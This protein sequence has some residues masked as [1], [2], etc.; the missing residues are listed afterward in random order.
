[1]VH[2]SHHHCTTIDQMH[3]GS[4]FPAV[5]QNIVGGRLTTAMPFER[6][7]GNQAASIS[8]YSLLLYIKIEGHKFGKRPSETD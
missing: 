7:S 8:E 6:G 4:V 5:Y 2:Q 3:V 1:M